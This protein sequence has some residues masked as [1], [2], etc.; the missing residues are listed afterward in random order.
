MSSMVFAPTAKQINC[1]VRNVEWGKIVVSQQVL[2]T[3][4]SFAN[5]GWNEGMVNYQKSVVKGCIHYTLDD[6]F[7]RR[8]DHAKAQE[9]MDMLANY[10]V[11]WGIH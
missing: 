8:S 3:L 10:L 1:I 7:N 11:E 6:L 9:R 4:K 5:N 2:D